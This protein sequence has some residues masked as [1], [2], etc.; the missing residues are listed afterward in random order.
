M[1]FIVPSDV[2]LATRHKEF[3]RTRERIKD[4]VPGGN[5]VREFDLDLSEYKDDVLDDLLKAAQEVKNVR[6]ARASRAIVQARAGDNGLN[7]PNFAAF[8]GVLVPYLQK[9]AF[10]AWIYVRRDDG[11]VYPELVTGIRTHEGT[12]YNPEPMVI[13]ATTYFGY[14]GNGNLTT[15]KDSYSFGPA[16]V[17]NK[18]VAQALLGKG[19][20][21]ETKDLRKQYDAEM[22][23]FNKSIAPAFAKQFRMNGK[24]LMVQEDEHSVRVYGGPSMSNVRVINDHNLDE[25]GIQKLDCESEIMENREGGCEVPVQPLV[26]IFDLND[27]IYYWVHSENLTPYVYDKGL[28]DKLIL[29]ASH[30]DLLDI[31]TTDIDAFTQDL[32]EGRSSGNVILAQGP[33]GVGKTMTA[34]V[35]SEIREMPLYR[36]RAGTLGTTAAELS[37]ALD[38][39]FERVLRWGCL[40]LLDDADVFVSERDP[41]GK[42][43]EQNAIVAEFLRILEMYSFLFFLNTNMTGAID[44]A[45][46]SRCVAVLKYTYPSKKNLPRIWKVMAELNGVKLSEKLI[47]DLVELLPQIAPRDL[48]Q[49]FRLTLRV[50]IARKEKLTLDAFRKCSILRGVELNQDKPTEAVAE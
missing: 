24:P 44:E 25:A 37:K 6:V 19:I 30:R 48:K 10:D 7:I 29:P 35:Y 5:S 18:T 2:L 21:R 49:I 43:M 50:T 15:C 22:L 42:S 47:A 28:R 34:E 32:V 26:Q 38:V 11:R 1:S 23:R 33:P 39:I 17:S 8:K 40:L 16:D 36:V 27:H 14:D 41:K 46:I 45:V 4:L 20:C 9:G 13:I 3:A 12:R 31:I